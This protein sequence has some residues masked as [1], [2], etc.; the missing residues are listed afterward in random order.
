DLLAPPHEPGLPWSCRH[1]APFCLDVAEVRGPAQ[2]GAGDIAILG[3]AYLLGD[4]DLPGLPGYE[5]ASCL[6]LELPVLGQDPGDEGRHH[7]ED[8]DDRQAPVRAAHTA[9]GRPEGR[10]GPHRE[11][12]GAVLVG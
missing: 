10:A 9:R 7:H 1:F 11:E 12:V 5:Q 6:L 4:H 8:P 3:W 2:P